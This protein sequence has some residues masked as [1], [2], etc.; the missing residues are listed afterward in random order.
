MPASRL[1]LLFPVLLLSGPPRAPAQDR[2][3]PSAPKET[4]ML[5]LDNGLHVQLMPAPGGDRA[6][7]LV[8]FDLGEE[9]DPPGSSGLAHL[10]EHLYVTAACKGRPARDAAAFARAHPMGWNA[11][12]GRDYTVIASVVPE[13]EVPA[14]LG[15]AAARMA[16]LRVT[17]ADLERELPRMQL[18]LT[19]MYGG[20]P[21]LGA[22]NHAFQRALPLASG[23]R[24]GGVME[25][26]RHL[27]AEQVQ[28][29]IDRY[30]KPAN[31]RLVVAGAFDE[32]AVERAVTR[33][34]SPLSAGSPAPAPQKPE[35]PG[36]GKPTVL[37]VPPGPAAEEGAGYAA[38]AWSL[39]AP[40]EPGYAAATVLATHL[41]AGSMRPGGDLQVSWQPLDRPEG[42]AVSV[43]VS[44]AAQVV[45]TLRDR[46]GGLLL[47]ASREEEL[48]KLRALPRRQLGAMLGLVSD[49]ALRRV[50]P[51]GAAFAAGRR[52]QLGLDP[53]A[54]R[55]Q[56]QEL[57]REDLERTAS[58]FA[59]SGAGVVLLVRRD[60]PR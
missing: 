16:S 44:G 41:A 43:P 55:A 27:D 60:S 4:G 26:L 14:E 7:V 47:T 31:A 12:T 49:R 58:H 24:K 8:L 23:A 21:R 40:G 9:Q 10:V 53:E 37:R 17:A 46:V 39:P 52:A 19:N 13:Q 20:M 5:R 11:Q 32:E 59:G 38:L 18:E 42:L 25:H 54:L 45:E 48:A 35:P 2:R 28:Q 6:A 3:S 51:Y 22:V 56:L 57:Q 30:Y 50:N 36:G 34:F 1:L 15:E 33:L 29:R